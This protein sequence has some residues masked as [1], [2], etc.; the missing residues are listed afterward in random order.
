MCD[1]RWRRLIPLKVS[2]LSVIR[3]FTSSLS[4]N[5]IFSMV[6]IYSFPSIAIDGMSPHPSHYYNEGYEKLQFLVGRI[7]MRNINP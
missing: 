7:S 3:G 2:V 6:L 1:N 4:I 5:L